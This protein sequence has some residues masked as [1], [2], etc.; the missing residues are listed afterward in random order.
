MA[1]ERVTRYLEAERATTGQ[2]LP[3]GEV[4][5]D[6][7]EWIVAHS[8]M[9]GSANR[10]GHS[11]KSEYRFYEKVLNVKADV[12]A[13]LNSSLPCDGRPLRSG[14]LQPIT[15]VSPIPGVR[16]DCGCVDC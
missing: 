6:T 16:A 11:V 15:P 8:E 1:S 12:A 3:D 10:N 4:F 13:I 7:S 14:H 9:T 5:S 2:I